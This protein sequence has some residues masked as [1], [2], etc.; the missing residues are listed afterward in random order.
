MNEVYDYL[1]KDEIA[2]VE[3]L[4]FLDERE[5]VKQLFEHYRDPDR[6]RIKT[7]FRKKSAC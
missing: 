2:R 3:R 6:V 7:L 4:E 1:P 5:L